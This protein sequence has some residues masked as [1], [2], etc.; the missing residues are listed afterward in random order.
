MS[1]RFKM[2]FDKAFTLPPFAD[3][4]ATLH[5]AESQGIYTINSWNWSNAKHQ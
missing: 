4:Y 5:G 2:L 1:N 3:F